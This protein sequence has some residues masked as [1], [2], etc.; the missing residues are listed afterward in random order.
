MPFLAPSFEI[1][2]EDERA[3]KLRILTFH[4]L[5][6]RRI[7]LSRWECERE[8]I[9]RFREVISLR[10]AETHF[11]VDFNLLGEDLPRADFTNT[12]M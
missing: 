2:G 4:L 8:E 10:G 1:A 12:Q 3:I 6:Y 5:P 9:A 7:H 11:E